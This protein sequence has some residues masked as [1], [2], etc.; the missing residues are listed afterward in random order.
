[1]P[2]VGC[3][4]VHTSKR[5]AYSTPYSQKAMGCLRRDCCSYSFPKRTAVSYAAPWVILSCTCSRLPFRAVTC[6]YSC[7]KDK[8]WLMSFT[9]K[10]KILASG[11]GAGLH[12]SHCRSLDRERDATPAH[13]HLSE[14]SSPPWV[15]VGQ[16]VCLGRGG[17]AC[18]FSQLRTA[19]HKAPHNCCFLFIPHSCLRLTT[20]VVF[21]IYFGVPAQTQST[22][23]LCHSEQ[24]RHWA[25]SL[26]S[27]AP[28]AAWLRAMLRISFTASKGLSSFWGCL[29]TS[30]KQFRQPMIKKNHVY[31]CLRYGH[32]EVH[33]PAREAADATPEGESRLKPLA[34]AD[35]HSSPCLPNLYSHMARTHALHT[36]GHGLRGGRLAERHTWVTTA[37]S[38][39]GGLAAPNSGT[40][41][42]TSR[43]SFSTNLS[44]TKQ[45]KSHSSLL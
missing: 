33:T 25:S 7:V 31:V 30:G 17:S 9:K 36:D 20:F 3:D 21:E 26:P 45:Y 14:S 4:S 11:W 34:R 1:M 5:V 27:A 29:W 24:N 37:K 41:P 22:L 44:P 40:E 19:V 32:D 8:L 38:E 2:G 42:P 6:F 16:E 10:N 13:P 43:C 35:E 15:A 12:H 39:Q 28:N 23:Q 18:P